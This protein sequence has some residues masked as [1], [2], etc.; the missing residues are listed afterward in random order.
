MPTTGRHTRSPA[1]L[2]ACVALL[3]AGAMLSGC[4]SGGR[5]APGAGI[6]RALLAEARPIGRG[7]RFHP[8]ARGPVIGR[9]RVQL[10]RRSAVHVE[11]FAANRVLLL[12]AGIGTRAPLQF[13]AARITRAGCYGSLITLDPTGLVLVRPGSRLSLSDL[14]RTWGQPLTPHRIASFSTPAQAGVG[15]FVDG[16]RWSGS[17]RTVPLARH[18]EIVLE[19]GPYVQ[20]HRSYTFPPGT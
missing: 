13:S 17:P 14:F 3:A 12:P 4:S 1:T 15:V 16:R 10:G 11:V 8:P 7:R 19:I 9:C 20:P 6:P 18:A 2:R 5:K